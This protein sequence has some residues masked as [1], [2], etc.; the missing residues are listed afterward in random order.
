VTVTGNNYHVE[1]GRIGNVL[2]DAERVVPYQ[3]LPLTVRILIDPQHNGRLW[4]ADQIEHAE[5][6]LVEEIVTAIRRSLQAAVR[7]VRPFSIHG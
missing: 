2:M 4:P 7:Q 3:A 6:E 5:D 1:A